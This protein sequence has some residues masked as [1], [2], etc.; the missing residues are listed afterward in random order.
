MKR[1]DK[2]VMSF[3]F[4]DPIIDKIDYLI[5]E[6]KENM[7]RLGLKPSTRKQIIEEAIRDYYLRKINGSSDPDTMDRIRL[8]IDD[9]ADERFGKMKRTLDEILL[10][11]IKNDLANRILLNSDCV[12]DP[13]PLISIA[14]SEIV[15]G[16]CRWDE[17]LQDYM[18]RNKTRIM[19]EMHNP[20]RF[21]K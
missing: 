17:V 3:R 9:A 14:A 19:A 5:E 10:L 12:P 16:E 8:M 20:R 2:K 1:D 18:T 4:E 13:H 11:V 6:D 15:K 21:S 7:K